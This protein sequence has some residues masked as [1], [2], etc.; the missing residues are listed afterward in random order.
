MGK[1]ADSSKGSAW[2]LFLTVHAV[3]VEKMEA[4]LAEAG[5][6]PLS[7]YDVLWAL[8]RAEDR[9]L[10]MSELAEM[11]VLS[12]SNLTR[13]VDRLDSAG[14]VGRERAEEDRRGAFAVITAEGR[15]MRKKM[16]PVYSAA[17]KALFE[18]NISSGEAARM[19]ETLRRILDAVREKT[20]VA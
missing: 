7:W 17:I 5:L 10:R 2:A 4:R 16:W 14:L 15:A 8:E 13:L 18:D 19:A 11:T 1:N 12:R 6:P 9:R 20:A 3:L